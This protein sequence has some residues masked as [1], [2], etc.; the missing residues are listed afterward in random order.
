M[1]LTFTDPNPELGSGFPSLK[2]YTITTD[3]EKSFHLNS[4]KHLDNSQRN[5][6]AIKQLRFSYLDLFGAP[7]KHA[8]NE[9]NLNVPKGQIY[10]LLG[11]NGAGKTT[12]IKCM[13]ARLRPTSGSIS[14]F[15]R[16]PGSSDSQ[17]P[18]MTCMTICHKYLVY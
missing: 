7:V 15:G 10:A 4:T 3:S 17:I 2:S 13:V 12:L 8:L 18:G 9:L 6:V 14:I 16:T 5:A 11:P 1:V